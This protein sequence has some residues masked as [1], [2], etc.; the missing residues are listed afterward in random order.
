MWLSTG[1]LPRGAARRD[2]LL[3]V[4]TLTTGALDAVTFVR[5]GKVFSSVITGNLVLLGIAGTPAEDQPVWPCQVTR[6]LA[7]EW[8][9]L[10]AF[11][12][13]WQAYVGHPVGAIRF[14]L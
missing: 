13:V 1:G 3:I 10:A 14:A 6:A 7:V 11:Y 4:L 12:G 2:V 8:G 5:L 9:V